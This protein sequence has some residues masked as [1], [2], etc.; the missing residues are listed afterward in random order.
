MPSSIIPVLIAVA[1]LVGCKESTGIDL[2]AVSCD[3]SF[4]LMDN[5]NVLL[6]DYEPGRKAINTV[7]SLKLEQVTQATYLCD[8]RALAIGYSYRGPKG[9]DSGIDLLGAS[10]TQSTALNEEGFAR[11]VSRGKDLIVST[12]LVRRKPMA[13]SEF[14]YLSLREYSDWPE[15]VRGHPVAKPEHVYFD[16]LTISVP[17]LSV[18]R[19]LRSPLVDDMRVE[20]GKL[21][22]SSAFDTIEVDLRTGFRTLVSDISFLAPFPVNSGHLLQASG[23]YFAVIGP[24]PNTAQKTEYEA[25][26][27]YFVDA[28]TRRAK[29]L[30]KVDFDLTYAA[31]DLR[32]VFLFGAKNLAVYHVAEQRIEVLTLALHGSTVTAFAPIEAGYAVFLSKP[33]PNRPGYFSGGTIAVFSPSFDELLATQEIAD[34]GPPVL[35]SKQAPTNIRGSF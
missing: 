1:M 9:E 29:L 4:S 28:S 34:F 5:R 31:A 17:N 23:R 11:F 33:T 32:S 13:S 25:N 10:S 7:V 21:L 2:S 14:G 22:I 6:F 12:T 15:R 3:N 20:D 30:A 8:A 18:T 27:L 16:L 19:R 24:R 35:T 26:S